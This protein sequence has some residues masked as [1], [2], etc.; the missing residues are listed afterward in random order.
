MR[1]PAFATVANLG[2]PGRDVVETVASGF[3][4][5]LAGAFP[6]H[7]ALLQRVHGTS[8]SESERGRSH[9]WQVIDRIVKS[10]RKGTAAYPD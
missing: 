5:E 3:V 4:K 10:A 2:L 1:D 8:F 9:V 7:V 6:D